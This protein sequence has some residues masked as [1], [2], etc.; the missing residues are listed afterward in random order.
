[1]GHENEGSGLSGQNQVFYNT[2][3]AYRRARSELNACVASCSCHVRSRLLRLPGHR[4]HLAPLL[5]RAVDSAPLNIRNTNNRSI[6]KSP[7]FASSIALAIGLFFAIAPHAFAAANIIRTVSTK[8]NPALDCSASLL[9]QYSSGATDLCWSGTNTSNYQAFSLKALQA[10]VETFPLVTNTTPTLELYNDT[11]ST[12]FSV[13]LVGNIGANQPISCQGTT[14]STGCQISGPVGT[15]NS[16]TSPDWTAVY[17]AASSTTSWPAVVTI[18]FFGVP[19]NSYV[20]LQWASWT[21]TDQTGIHFGG[22]VANYTSTVSSCGGNSAAT[23]VRGVVY[24]PNGVDPLPNAL[25]YVPASAPGTLTPGVQCIQATATPG[26]GAVTST[27]SAADGTFT[28]AGVP[29]G[30]NIPIVIQVGKWRI[31]RTIATVTACDNT[32]LAA[33]STTL[34]S[35]QFAG[36]IPRIALVTGSEDA[37]QCVLRKTGVL[38]SEFT[39]SNGTGRINLFLGG[40]NP[41]AHIDLSTPGQEALVGNQATLGNYDMVMLPSQGAVYPQTATDLANIYQ[42][43]NVGGR[44]FASH[45]SV[46]W[47]ATNPSSGV[48]FGAAAQWDSS[49]VNTSANSAAATVNSSFPGASMLSTWLGSSIINP[50]NGPVT[51]PTAYADQLG[52]IAPTQSWLSLNTSLTPN[53]PAHPAMQLTFNTPVGAAAENQC[54]RVLYTEY[55]AVKANANGS[56]FPAECNASPMTTGEHLVEYSLFDLANTITPVVAASVSQTFTTSPS[57]FTQGDSADQVTIG[58][59]NTSGTV[60]LGSS[61]IVNGTLPSGVTLNTASF[62]SGGWSCSSKFNSSSFTCKRFNSLAAN[63]TDPIVLPL[64]IDAT[65]TVGTGA[66]VTDIVSGGGLPSPVAGSGSISVTAAASS[67]N[68]GASQTTSPCVNAKA[69][70]ATTSPLGIANAYNLVALKGNISDAADITGRIAAAG[71]VTLATTIGTALRDGDPYLASASADGGPWAIVAAAGIPTSDSFNINAGGNVY[72]LTPT[73]AGFNFVNENYSGSIYAGSTLVTGGT[74][75]I[76]FPSLSAGISNLSSQ[77]SVETANGIICSVDSTGSIIP[78]NGCPSTPIYFNSS[79]QHYNPSWLVLYGTDATTNVFNLTQSQFET[80]STNLDI[81]VPTG[82][83]TVINVTGADDT[84]H[85]DVYFQGSTVTDA[86]AGKILYNF[87]VATTLTINGQFDGTVLAPNA[88]LSGVSQMGG[89]FI[90]ASIG[91]TGEAH[92]IPFSGTLPNSGTPPVLSVTCGAVTS[93]EVGL[94]FNSGPITVSGGTA[95]Y[96]FSILG[97]LPAGLTLSATTGAITGTP[98]AAGTFSVKVTD[99]AG[100]SSTGCAIIINEVLSVTCAAVTSGEVGVAFNSGAITV[101][102]GTAPYSFSILGTLP[103]GLILNATI[104]AITGTPTSAGTFSVKVTDAAGA[105]STGCAIT[106]NAVLS[107]TCAAVTSGEVGIAFNSGAITVS[108]GTA[109]YIFSILG[110]LQ[111]GLTLSATTGAIIGTPTSAGIFSVKVTDA[112]GASSTGCP[113]TINLVLSVTC[114]AVT[115]GEVGVAFNSGAT[116]VSGGTAPYTLSILGTLP[117][118]LTLN[119]TTGAITGTPTTAGTFS[120]KVTDANGASSTGC[121]II[122]NAVLSVTSGAV[123]SGEVGVAFNS[124]VI[125]VSGGTAPY[126][127]SILGTLAAGVTLNLSTGAVTGAPTTAGTFSVKVTDAVGASSTGGTITINPVL[128]VTCAAVTSGEVGIAFNSGA[129]TVSGGTAPYTF[130]ILGTLPAGLTLNTTTGAITGTPTSAGTFSVK[131]TD[132]NGASSTACAII[133]NAVLSVTCAAIT[134]GEVGVAFSSGAIT[135]SGGTTPY[136]FSIL[137]TLPA[138]LALNTITGAITGTSTTAGTFAVKVTDAAG[139][140]STGCAIIINAVLS[141]TSGA[142]TSGEVGVALN[143][144]AITVSGG[145]APYTFSILGTL[146]AGVTLNPSTGAITGTPTTA[147]TFSVKVT[148]AAGASSTGSAITINPVLSVTCATAIGGQAGVAFSSGAITVSGGT[149]PYAF[150]ILGALPAGLTFSTSTGLVIGIPTT[151]GTFSVKVTDAVGVSSTGCA[152]T[153]TVNLAASLSITKSADSASITAGGLAGYKVIISNLGLTTATGLTLSDPLPGGVGSDI[154]WVIDSTT[155]NPTAFTITGSTASQQLA[156]SGTMSV[157]AATTITNTGLTVITGDIGLSPG[158]AVTGFL[159]GV[160]TGS[161]HAADSTAATAQTALTTAYLAAAGKSGGTTVAGDL[162]GRTLTAGVYTSASSLAN[163]GDLTLDA[164][165]DPNAVFTFQMGSTLT[166]LSGSHIILANGANAC[167]VFWQVGSSA[168][169][170]TYSVFKGN[171]LA[172]TSIT[173]TTGVNLQGTALARNG[174]VTLDSDTISG[175]TQSLAPGASLVVHITGATTVNDLN[176]SPNT[177]LLTNTATICATNATCAQATAGI[178]INPV[179]SGTVSGVAISIGDAAI[180]AYWQNK[181]GQALIDGMNGS[182]SSTNLANWLAANFPYLYGVQSTTNL[183]GKT[184]IDVAA[185]FVAF[186]GQTGLTTN[187]QMMAVALAVYTTNTVLAGTNIAS[188][189]GFNTSATGTGPKTILVSSYGT[190]WGLASNVSYGVMQLLQQANS[191][192]QRGT[193]NTTAFNN[194]FSLINLTG[195]IGSGTNTSAISFTCPTTTSGAINVAFDSGAITLSGGTAPYTFSIVNTLPAGLALNTSTGEITGIPTASGSF[196]IKVTDAKGII[197]TG[198]SFS[199][200]AGYALSVNPS[201]VTVVAGETAITT[202][203][204]SPYGGYTGNVSFSCSGLPLG[205]TCA[206]SPS[207]LTAN[208]LNAVQTSTLSVTTTA[209][210]TASI[211]QNRLSSPPT[212]ASILFLP[213]MLLGGLLAWHRRSLKRGLKDILLL[214]LLSTVIVGGAGC[215]SGI[216]RT[217]TGTQKVTV[218]ATTSA[219]AITSTGSTRD[220]TATFTLIVT[221]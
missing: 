87:P 76:D 88:A 59:K 194:I 151:A 181:N 142:V 213:G 13:K 120:V 198:C 11:S 216:L 8:S 171:I 217:P 197:A 192:V 112:A 131:V 136:S 215:A 160:V 75:P 153:I 63:A 105:S 119:T 6:A 206:F 188:A 104:G 86:N 172:L 116:T 134:S 31:Q 51:L 166:T 152:F 204:F 42:W 132:A 67:S 209:N 53:G 36:D 189:Q 78:D 203:T 121:A 69:S 117:A 71:Q 74:S 84:L 108:G 81:E 60:A 83:T 66:L 173:I 148:D 118:G 141:V 89:V 14:G 176:T 47:L 128:S 9:N 61:L 34:P 207:S 80:T 135:V 41:G 156:M 210:G 111:T 23:T 193:F 113:I 196:S 150:S 65:A 99:A 73:T 17:P 106:M 187:A 110:T 200:G 70:S 27:V 48:G 214:M 7:T 93:G 55:P 164:Q 124:G 138:A 129:T 40:G 147:G 167:N 190:G 126:S 159:P 45:D 154:Q 26:G 103:A 77:L 37:I 178:L 125:T 185:Q 212:L 115:S 38:D 127:F 175:C 50:S 29:A 43:A 21:G 10:G 139:P 183:T 109:P 62:V 46:T 140:S 114:A 4:D 30:A 155:G 58:I 97:T 162:A 177:G 186:F 146:P 56:T 82:S 72:S 219:S 107:V 2:C 145:T 35:N 195:A 1:M 182:S 168:T 161:I 102:G 170:G 18:T 57:S 123:T 54:G 5:F 39:N 205:A 25:V 169:L 49:Q 85:T 96:R 220:Q 32:S 211:A 202:F 221:Q 12:T 201:T 79:S 163:S 20:G 149:A 98:T 64:A 24:A 91:S 92:Y 3:S 180:S 94:A 95:P 218:V 100:A 208:G 165:G 130:S 157:L 179:V 144:G 68:C 33:L 22:Q 199:I 90:A 101:S 133:I 122:I 16:Q 174:A 28:L 19:L 184:N 15:F 191:Q 158:T 44:L 137:G 52:A 143:S